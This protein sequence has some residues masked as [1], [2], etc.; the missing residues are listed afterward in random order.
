LGNSQTR[1]LTYTTISGGKNP[2]ATRA[3]AFFQSSQT[4]LEE[5]FTPHANH[6]TSGVQ[7]TGNFII[8][9]ALSGKQDDLGTK[10]LEIR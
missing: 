2:G 9:E 4:L 6:F 5:T 7:A 3:R 10:H 8:G 1:A